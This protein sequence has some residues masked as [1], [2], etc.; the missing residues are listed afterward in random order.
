MISRED[1]IRSREGFDPRAECWLSL[2]EVE[3]VYG[4][5]E[6][7]GWWWCSWRWIGGIKCVSRAEAESFVQEA[8]REAAAQNASAAQTA[9]AA[10]LALGDDDTVSSTYPEGYIPT[11]WSQGPEVQVIIEGQQGQ[12]DNTGQGRPHYE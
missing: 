12:H 10:V 9:A 2:Y 5:P 8:E 3:Q 6:E 11:G 4:G 1:I 7:G